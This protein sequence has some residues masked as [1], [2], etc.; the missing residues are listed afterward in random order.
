MEEAMKLLVVS[1][2][3]NQ[4]RQLA[5]LPD[6]VIDVDDELGAF[7]L[8]DA[9]GCFAIAPATD[10]AAGDQVH[11]KALEGAPIDRMQ[12]KRATRKK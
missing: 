2:Y 12:H 1:T 4:A 8:R 3:I 9:P 10:Q 7:L 5:Y 11:A 6:R